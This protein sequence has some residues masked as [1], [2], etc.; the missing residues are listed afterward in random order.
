MIKEIKEHKFQLQYIASKFHRHCIKLIDAQI[1]KYRNDKNHDQ[2]NVFNKNIKNG[3]I[4]YTVNYM[5]NHKSP[6]SDKIKNKF[7]KYGIN[8]LI[9]VIEKVI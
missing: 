1:K 8:K 2:K 4:K 3:K 5:R 7:I 6:A 9:E